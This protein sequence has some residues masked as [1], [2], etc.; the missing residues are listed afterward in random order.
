MSDDDEDDD[1]LMDYHGGAPQ[2]QVKTEN[3]DADAIWRNKFDS[4]GNPDVIDKMKSAENM[5]NAIATGNTDQV[6]LLLQRFVE[7]V[8]NS[9]W[10]LQLY[11]FPTKMIMGSIFL[12]EFQIPIIKCVLFVLPLEI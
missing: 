2:V 8:A 6:R 10:K 9:P 1:S 7:I 12:V 11:I 4:D 3:L 5:C